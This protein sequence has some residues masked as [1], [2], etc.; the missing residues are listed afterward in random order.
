MFEPKPDSF[1][2][3]SAFM[4][5]G[6]PLCFWNCLEAFFYYLKHKTHCTKKRP[7][8]LYRTVLKCKIVCK[9]RL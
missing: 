4:T 9:I 7:R 8:F 1:N 3:Q 6:R 5:D 2:K